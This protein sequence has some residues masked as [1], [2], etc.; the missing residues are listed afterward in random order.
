MS[1][2]NKL[3]TMLEEKTEMNECL[4]T[5]GDYIGPKKIKKSSLSDK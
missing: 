2:K 3:K 1:I 4:V 5:L